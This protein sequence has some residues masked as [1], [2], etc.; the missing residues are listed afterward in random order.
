MARECY[1]CNGTGEI[2]DRPCSSC[3]G[4]GKVV[5]DRK[6]KVK[7]PRG[8]DTGVKLK[9]QGE[10]ESGDLGALPGDLYVVI[11][12]KD[13]KFFTRQGS[14]IIVQYPISF[15]QAALGAEIEVPTLEGVKKI[16]VAPGTQFGDT[17]V[18]KEA[19]MPSLTNR[20]NRGSQIVE[21]IIETPVSLNERQKELLSEFAQISG[22]KVHPKK[23][24]FFEKFKKFFEDIT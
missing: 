2:I 8:V 13:H 4:E 23:S 14:N 12:V 11:V 22:E 10:G 1:N 16:E 6:I 17:I 7:V 3:S 15:V 20:G 21:I 19:G 9:L 18:I 24:S 5:V